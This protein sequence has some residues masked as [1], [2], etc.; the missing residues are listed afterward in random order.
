MPTDKVTHKI[1]GF[2]YIEFA[3]KKAMKRAKEF[4]GTIF[5]NRPL[6]V[7]RKLKT[8][9]GVSGNPITKMLTVMNDFLNLPK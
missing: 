4:N 6:T 8:I 2:A 5:M 7:T 3:S 9:P 1:L